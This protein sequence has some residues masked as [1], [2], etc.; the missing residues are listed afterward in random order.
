[1]KQEAQVKLTYFIYVRF[2][3]VALNKNY[4]SLPRVLIGELQ[5]KVV[6]MVDPNSKLRETQTRQG[7]RKDRNSALPS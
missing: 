3:G 1:M 7:R 6:A 5:S 2:F 4:N